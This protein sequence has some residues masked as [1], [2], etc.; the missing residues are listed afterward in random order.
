MQIL[1]INIRL[2]IGERV[3]NKKRRHLKASGCYLNSS[4][5]IFLLFLHP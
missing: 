1:F 2:S 4:D 3:F 5:N